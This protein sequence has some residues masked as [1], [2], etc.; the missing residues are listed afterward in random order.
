MTREEL[1]KA[2]ENE[3]TVWQLKYGKIKDIKLNNSY[4]ILD[5]HLKIRYKTSYGYTVVDR[6]YFDRLHKTK[7]EAEWVA[8][9]HTSRVEKFEPPTDLKTEEYFEFMSK[10]YGECTI[11]PVS[12]IKNEILYYV[13]YNQNDEFSEEFKTYQE[14]VEYAK[15]LFEGKE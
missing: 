8:N 9:M 14:A 1:E 6:Y 12:N 4:I 13:V 3:E 7:S 10:K 15:K 5:N 2:I 11:S